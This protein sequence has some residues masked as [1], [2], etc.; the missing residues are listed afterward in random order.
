MA[1][2]PDEEEDAYVEEYIS[3]NQNPAHYNT[4]DPTEK[5]RTNTN[6]PDPELVVYI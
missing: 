1:S 2:D 6:T 4:V 3:M 5:R